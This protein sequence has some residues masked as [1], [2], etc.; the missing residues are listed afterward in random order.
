MA[1]KII[2][3]D[4][5]E[6]ILKALETFFGV[7]GYEVVTCAEPELALERIGMEKF[8]VALLDINMPQMTGIE[9]LR[10]IKDSRPTVQVVMMTAYTTIEKAIECVEGGAS[11]YLLKPFHD[12][13]ELANI[14]HMAAERVRRWEVVA[15]ESLRNPKDVTAHQ[16][17][18]NP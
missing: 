7:R 17:G 14:V 13:D 16:L 10:R 8:H 12:L 1:Y 11:D 5:E 2:I 6:Q 18:P 4:D 15:R 3:V 9:M